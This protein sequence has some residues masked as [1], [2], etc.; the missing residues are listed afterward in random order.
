MDFGQYKFFLSHDS[1]WYPESEI[2]NIQRARKTFGRTRSALLRSF[3]NVGGAMGGH[4]FSGV[5]LFVCLPLGLLY[6]FN[7]VSVCLS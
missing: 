6:A 5:F 7:G 2:P 3:V 4:R 1:F